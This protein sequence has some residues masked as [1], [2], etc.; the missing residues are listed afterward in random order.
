M[1]RFRILYPPLSL[2]FLICTME[3]LTAGSQGREQASED[4]G[5]QW[6]PRKQQSGQD[7]AMMVPK[8]A[9]DCSPFRKWHFG[10]WSRGVYSVWVSALLRGH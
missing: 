9:S 8:P 10:V 6:S 5:T 3:L 7:D 4:P 2:Y 1:V